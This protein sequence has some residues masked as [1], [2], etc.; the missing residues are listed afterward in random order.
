MCVKYVEACSDV[1]VGWFVSLKVSRAPESDPEGLQTRSGVSVET[2]IRLTECF[3]IITLE[4]ALNC[5]YY[6]LNLNPPLHPP[7]PRLRRR[8]RALHQEL[9]FWTP[10]RGG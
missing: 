8:R 2:V 4:E 10:A 6:D 5:T 3:F 7:P 9:T 1:F